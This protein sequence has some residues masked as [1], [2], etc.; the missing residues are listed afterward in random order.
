MSFLSYCGVQRARLNH[1]ARWAANYFARP[2][3]LVVGEYHGANLGDYLLGQAVSGGL[4][5]LGR[6]PVI[7]TLHNLK[8]ER[9]FAGVPIL[10]GGGNILDNHSLDLTSAYWA[11]I[12]CP[13]ICGVGL[14][15]VWS[16]VFDTHREFFSHFSSILFRSVTQTEQAQQVFGPTAGTR[17]GFA[18]DMAWLLRDSLCELGAHYDSGSRAIGINIMPLYLRFGHR[19]HPELAFAEGDSFLAQ[20]QK[21]ADAYKKLVCFAVE[22]YL[23]RGYRVMH[24]PFDTGDDLLA[25]QWLQPLGVHCEPYTTNIERVIGKMAA[26]RYFIPTRFHALL[27]AMAAG[28]PAKPI[29][30]AEKNADLLRQFGFSQWGEQVPRVFCENDANVKSL[31]VGDKSVIVS[32]D[33]SS[34]AQSKARA[35]LDEASHILSID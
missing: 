31:L 32:D 26:C 18:P 16:S 1:A 24:I 23:S 11:K 3:V 35:A 22:H 29:P 12:G 15:Y 28:I 8:R 5:R 17:L 6:S 2:D 19:G 4:R 27:C 21:E 7:L 25:R 34:E 33:L 9:K 20:A 13:P 30:Y 10:L 14:D